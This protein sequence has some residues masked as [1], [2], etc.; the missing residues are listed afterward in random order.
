[1]HDD[2]TKPSGRRRHAPAPAPD[3]PK[4]SSDDPIGPPT[5]R[6]KHFAAIMGGTLGGL[7]III[8]FVQAC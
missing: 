5:W 2:S 3:A 8:I 6:E 7:L 4:L 1:M